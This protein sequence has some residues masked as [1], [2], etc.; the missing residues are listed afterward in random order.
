MAKPVN[1]L[2]LKKFLKDVEVLNGL[3]AARKYSKLILEEYPFDNQLLNLSRLY[4]LSR[5]FY[6]TL[7]GIFSRKICSM[8]FRFGLVH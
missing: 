3:P 4:R 7:G 6:F 2:R 8:R 5:K 1:K